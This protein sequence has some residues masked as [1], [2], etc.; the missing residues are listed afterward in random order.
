ML[1]LPR[2]AARV[3]QPG[4]RVHRRRVLHGVGRRH[5]ARPPAPDVPA[6]R[7]RRHAAPLPPPHL[8]RLFQAAPRPLR[9]QSLFRH[10]KYLRALRWALAGKDPAAAAAR[11]PRDWLFDGAKDFV[12]NGLVNLP[13]YHCT[14]LGALETSCSRPILFRDCVP[15]LPRLRRHAD[16]HQAGEP[17][18]GDLLC[19]AAADRRLSPGVGIPGLLLRGLHGTE[20]IALRSRLRSPD[21]GCAWSAAPSASC[22]SAPCSPRVR[23]C[24]HLS[25][26]LVASP[27]VISS[28]R[29]AAPRMPSSTSPRGWCRP[30]PELGRQKAR[31]RHGG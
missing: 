8:C 30:G 6:P 27:S 9:S 29:R 20:P 21:R 3:S 28:S 14:D 17:S 15:D 11:A 16:L 1:A 10:A 7:R 22:R 31:E 2:Q 5:D 12:R 24:G 18:E 25:T 19:A 13:L 4:V 23:S 26:R